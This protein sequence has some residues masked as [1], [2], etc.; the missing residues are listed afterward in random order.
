MRQA[1]V[2]PS[3]VCTECIVGLAKG[4]SVSSR[5]AETRFAEKNRTP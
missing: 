1:C 5:F 3:S 4:A 2:R